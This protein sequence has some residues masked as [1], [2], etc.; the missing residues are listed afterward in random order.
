MLRRRSRG[1]VCFRKN[2]TKS[3]DED[4]VSFLVSDKD[5]IQEETD[6]ILDSG[7]ISHMVNDKKYFKKIKWKEI[8]IGVAKKKEKM[9][10]KGIGTIETENCI[11]NNVLFVPELSKNLLSVSAIVKN[12]GQVIFSKDKVEIRK[13]DKKFTAN[14]TKQ[15]LWKVN[16]K[17]E[18]KENALSTSEQET[19]CEWHR[20]LGHLGAKNMKR[21]MKLTDGISYA[22]DEI[23]EVTRQCE[24]CPKAKQVR[25]PFGKEREKA[26]RPLELI[27]TDVCGPIDPCTWDNR[28]YILT[29]LDDY[30]HFA[31]IYLL[32]RK[33]ELAEKVNNS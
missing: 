26:T 4:K 32:E 6:W 24:I 13:D 11:L 16:L 27:H 10:A 2:K 12:G 1:Q 15:G 19:A 25:T 21:L 3:K 17:K 23:E 33:Y 28:N 5:L 8:E 7:S 30:T 9:K 31:V 29:F 22:A 20:K 14:K 18:E